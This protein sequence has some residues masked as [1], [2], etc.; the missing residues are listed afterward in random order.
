M[1]HHAIWVG[2]M[3]ALAAGSINVAEAQTAPAATDT[4][5]TTKTSS[6]LEEIT[7]TAQKR[8]EDVRKVPL[9]VSVLSGNDLETQH[10][11]DFGDLTRSI[12]NLSFSGASGSGPGLN[13]IEIRGISS[14]AGQ[15]TVGI[16]L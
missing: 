15:S 7:V 3:A 13:N 16:Y 12:P 10:I 11:D 4:T 8:T 9:S 1:G 14:A 6:Q 5:V 2:A